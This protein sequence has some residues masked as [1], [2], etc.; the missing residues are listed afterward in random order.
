MTTLHPTRSNRGP[1]RRVPVW[2]IVVVGILV[3]ALLVGAGLLLTNGGDDDAPAAKATPT[4]T[5]QPADTTPP[6]GKTAVNV[7]NATA[8]AGLARDTADALALRS[9]TVG[10]VAN[11]PN[12]ATITGTA[13]VRYV[14]GATAQARWVAAQVPAA[15]M[16]QV[17][18]KGRKGAAKVDLVVGSGYTALATPAQATAAF[19]ASAPRTGC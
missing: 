10:D 14:P 3:G 18:A 2:A 19:T 1:I 4:C 12:K 13:V 17:A 8:R 11:D 7:Y 16:Q 5:P 9:F 6:A 15:T